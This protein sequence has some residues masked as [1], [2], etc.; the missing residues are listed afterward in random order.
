LRALVLT[1]LE[2]HKPRKLNYGSLWAKSAEEDTFGQE[3]TRAATGQKEN[4][5]MRGKKK[6]VFLG[7]CGVYCGACSTYCAYND[8]DQ[9]LIDWK[10]EIGMPR[11][12]IFCKGCY[13]NLINEWCS[14]C[15]FRKCVKQK[16][17]SY[18]FE[19]TECPCKKLI[20]FSKTRPHRIL[21]LRNLKQLKDI[22]I[23]E[24]LKQ[25]KKRWACSS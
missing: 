12:E 4:S 21:G 9:A 10:I 16:G 8:K 14:N 1:Y 2:G 25:Q 6:M 15:D 3:R 17:I 7:I 23:E 13:S 11:E 20:D 22:S 5:K 24:W 19:C 18:C